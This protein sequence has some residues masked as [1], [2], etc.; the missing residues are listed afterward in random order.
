VGGDFEKAVIRNSIIFGNEQ[1]ELI[2]DSYEDRQLNYLFDHCLTRIHEDSIDY[3]EDP[4]F[5][6]IINNENPLLDS[7]PYS[8]ELDTLSPAIDAGNPSHAVEIPF[9][10][11]GNNRLEDEAP[12]LGAYERIEP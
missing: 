10:M 2:I 11:K 9:D 1:M 3:L 6:A 8:F 7:V 4:R 12:D 5:T